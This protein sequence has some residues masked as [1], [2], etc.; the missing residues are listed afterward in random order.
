MSIPVRLYATLLLLNGCIE[1]SPKDAVTDDV[2]QVNITSM[3]PSGTSCSGTSDFQNLDSLDFASY[4]TY[5]TGSSTAPGT[6]SYVLTRHDS[7]PTTSC[8]PAETNERNPVSGDNTATLWTENWYATGGEGEYLLL[9]NTTGSTGAGDPINC[10]NAASDACNGVYKVT[11]TNASSCTNYN[12]IKVYLDAT[13]SSL[14]AQRRMDGDADCSAGSGRFQLMP[15]QMGDRDQD[16]SYHYAFLPVQKTGTGVMTRSAWITS[17]NQVS[18]PS[19]R[20]LR[21][22]KS[23][24]KFSFDQA[25][26][27]KDPT[28]V[29][30]VVNATNRYST[31]VIDGNATF[32]VSELPLSEIDDFTVDIGWSC[33]SSFTETSSPPGYQFRLSDIGCTG[34]NQKMTL[35]VGSGP[36]R[37]R[38]EQYGTA[39]VGRTEPTQTT[40][41]GKAFAFD[42]GPL[43]IDGV[44]LSSNTQQA[45]VK[46]NYLRWNSSDICTAGTYTF[47][48]E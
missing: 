14:M 25:D 18:V 31:G 7:G 6:S 16:G 1:I 8:T 12:D 41:E 27:L 17:I 47:A 48:A 20:T 38:L 10:T 28:V 2:V 30:S 45:S 11:I 15:V 37:V 21:V 39:A 3:N 22:I 9:C 32:V 24:K 29:A 26:A 42:R 19:G 40:T 13:S 44:V 46:I 23:D 33:S 36:N 43:S 5:G 35:R 4:E 34:Y